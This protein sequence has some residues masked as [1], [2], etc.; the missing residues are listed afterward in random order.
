MQKQCDGYKVAPFSEG[1]QIICAINRLGEQ[2]H[3]VHG[4]V[5][6]DVTMVRQFIREYEAATGTDI[7][8]TAFIVT[9]LGKAVTMNERVHAYRKGWSQ[10]VLF[11]DVDVNIAIEHEVNGEKV[12][13]TYII[14]AADK[15]EYQDINQEIQKAQDEVPDSKTAPTESPNLIWA[16][17]SFIN[18]L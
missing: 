5:K 4:L 8:F 7:S 11:D 6:V 10:P 16:L 2:K 13:L 15:K 14:R 1:R 17:P 9:C 3:I 12:P 18:K